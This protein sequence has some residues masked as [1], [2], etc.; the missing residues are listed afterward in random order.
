MNV[1]KGLLYRAFQ[2]ALLFNIPRGTR[3]ISFANKNDKEIGNPPVFSGRQKWSYA[4]SANLW[5][6]PPLLTVVK[7][8]AMRQVPISAS[9]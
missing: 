4:A 7:S 5:V 1:E 9:A 8:G 2:R 3:V 6:I